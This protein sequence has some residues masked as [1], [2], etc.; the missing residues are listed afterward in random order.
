MLH[1]A[2]RVTNFQP[3]GIRAVNAKQNTGF[4]LCIGNDQLGVAVLRFQ[5]GAF[6]AL[7]VLVFRECMWT[8]I[9]DT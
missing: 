8:A 5:L 7:A 9:N 2:F 6:D 3:R 4:A 1:V